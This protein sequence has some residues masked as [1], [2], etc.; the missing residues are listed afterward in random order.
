MT[1]PN[2]KP[3]TRE[4]TR[5][6]PGRLFQPDDER[7]LMA[8]AR[9]VIADLEGAD[10]GALALR[11]MHSPF[12]VPDLT[13]VVGNPAPRKSRL[14]LSVPPLLNEIDAGVVA[15]ASKTVPRTADRLASS[16]GWPLATLERRIPGLL[17]SRALREIKPARYVRR[18][19]LEPIGT[20]YAV[21]LK[22]ADWKRALTQGRTYRTW[23]NAYLLIVDYVSEGS[24]PDLVQAVRR[25][26]GGLVVAGSWIV[27][28][29]RSPRDPARR[30]WT[31]EHVIAASR[32]A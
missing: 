4:A 29:K 2:G 30:L 7:S 23:A 3:Q 19:A 28:P 22:M 13:V 26:R 6:R 11:E 27:K 25:D 18:A 5:Q 16:L 10:E 17:K 14:R 24:L 32:R 1:S 31:S 20:V 15:V 9:R 12:G 21:E 8:V